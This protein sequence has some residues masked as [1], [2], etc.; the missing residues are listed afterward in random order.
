MA[1]FFSRKKDT[2]CGVVIEIGSGSVA[3][4]I[5]LSSCRNAL[6]EMLY[7]RR[8][9]MPIRRTSTPA[10]RIR[11]MRRVLFAVMLDLER[12][13]MAVL[14]KRGKRLRV[15]RLLVSCAAPW[16]HTIT[17]IIRFEQ[18]TPFIV[19][20]RMVDEIILRAYDTEETNTGEHAQVLAD[21]GQHIVETAIIDITLNGYSVQAPY[22]KEASEIAIAHLRGL[23]PTHILIALE[24]IEKHIQGH[25]DMRIHTSAFILYCVLRDLYPQATSACIVAVSEEATEIGLVQNGILYESMAVEYGMHSL[26]RDLAGFAKTIPEEA[27]AYLRAY[28]QRVL[29]ETQDKALLRAQKR[30]VGFLEATIDELTKRYVLPRTMFLVLDQNA[31]QFFTDALESAIR[32]KGGHAQKTIV[33]LSSESTRDLITSPDETVGDPRLA[34]TTR[35]FHKLHA[36]GEMD[37]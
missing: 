13:G 34:I 24:G 6:P 12:R 17:Q 19:T 10:D 15:E 4:S 26:I 18:D 31:K 14:R 8:E 27:H 33:P 36:C 30:Y 11:F 28:K 7:A 35:F 9:Y 16:S 22:N 20:R 29:T 32:D 25:R 2:V 1:A 37:N 3:A 5:V 21:E 23:V